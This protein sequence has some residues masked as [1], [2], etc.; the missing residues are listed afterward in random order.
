MKPMSDKCFL[1]T[2]ILIYAHTDLDLQKQQAAQKVIA[3]ENTCLSTQVLQETANVLF[4]KFQ[5]DWPNIHIVLKE[6]IDYN[7]LH[8]NS[9]STISEAC[10]IAERYGFSF[11]DS[12][13]IAAALE[14]ECVVL[15]SEDMQHSI[16]IDGKLSI[17]N[18][19]LV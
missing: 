18:P 10:R 13:I 15:L 11:Y 9:S 1:D 4:K 12:L 17:R 2:N 6:M 5:F 3:S 8:I 7:D 19:F 14:S 16:V